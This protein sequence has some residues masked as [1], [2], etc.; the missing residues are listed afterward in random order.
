VKKRDRKNPSVGV[1][2]NADTIDADLFA[3]EMVDVAPLG[4]DPRGRVRTT[5]RISAPCGAAPPAD[6]VEG[7]HEDFTAPGVDRREV[8]KLKRGEYDVGNCL[9]LHGMTAVEACT[10][11]ERFIEKNRHGR[12]RCVCIVHGRG[13]HSEQHASVLKPRVRAYLSSHRSVLAFADAP[14]S[15]GG[16]GAVYV[17]LR[18]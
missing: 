17:L 12:R 16:A 8:R 1:E 15:D 14:R 4:Q 18:K 9:D 11:V 6:A 10:S 5:S 7:S 3:R 13:L 2:H